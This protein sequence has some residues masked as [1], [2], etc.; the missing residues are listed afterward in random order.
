LV[1][2]STVIIKTTT[3]KDKKMNNLQ[4]RTATA[5]N[6][7]TVKITANGKTEEATTKLDL[8]PT[9][10]HRELSSKERLSKQLHFYSLSEAKWKTINFDEAT[11]IKVLTYFNQKMPVTIVKK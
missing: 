3:E 6:Y 11:E 1:V 2:L 7:G 4:A 8:I 5:L 9:E 10:A